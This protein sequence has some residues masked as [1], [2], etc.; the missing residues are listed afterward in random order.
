MRVIAS[1]PGPWYN[2]NGVLIATSPVADL[3]SVITEQSEKN[4]AVDENGNQING[5][6]DSPNRHDDH[7]WCAA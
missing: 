1:A 6:G 2:A 4:T 7:D 3:A 5:V